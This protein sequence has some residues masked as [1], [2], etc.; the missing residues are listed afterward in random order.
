MK[1]KDMPSKRGA[2]PA[3]V[4]DVAFE[5][6]AFLLYVEIPRS[7]LGSDTSYRDRFFFVFTQ[8]LQANSR[9]SAIMSLPL[10]FQFIIH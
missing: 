9:I 10:P 4:R 6:L 8:T 2:V 7:N 5:W 1:L 3:L